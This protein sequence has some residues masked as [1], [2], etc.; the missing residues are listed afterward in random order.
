M[1]TFADDLARLTSREVAAAKGDPERL[2][3]MIERLAAALGFTVAIA[4]GGK[5]EAIDT[6]LAGAEAYA[7][8][9]AVD[10]AAIASL[11]AMTRGRSG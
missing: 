7:H 8:A 2:A 5:G 9:E 1:R 6:M 3:N 4:A 10:R 11:L